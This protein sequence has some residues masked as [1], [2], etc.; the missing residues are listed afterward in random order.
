MYVRDLR[1]VP[2][3]KCQHIPN[4]PITSTCH[5]PSTIRLIF[6]SRDSVGFQQRDNKSIKKEKKRAVKRGH[7]RSEPYDKTW[8][9]RD[10]IHWR[11]R[12]WGCMAARVEPYLFGNSKTARRRDSCIIAEKGDDYRSQ[13]H[14]QARRVYHGL[15]GVGLWMR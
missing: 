8:I 10:R 3:A 1:N 11:C 9:H 6:K 14:A 12:G 5:T 7:L 13:L 4:V 2:S 15:Q